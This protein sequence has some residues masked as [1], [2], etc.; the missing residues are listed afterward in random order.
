MYLSTGVYHRG[1]KEPHNKFQNCKTSWIAS[2]VSVEN[3][4]EPFVLPSRAEFVLLYPMPQLPRGLRVHCF[5]DCLTMDSTEPVVAVKVHG[6]GK[7]QLSSLSMQ[8]FLICDSCFAGPGVGDL[9]NC[10]LKCMSMVLRH[11][12]KAFTSYRDV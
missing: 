12:S 10:Q 3:S 6:L 11:V 9:L 4:S 5:L 1:S 7:F 8:L 2:I